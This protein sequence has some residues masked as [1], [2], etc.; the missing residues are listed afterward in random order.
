MLIHLVLYEY[1]VFPFGLGKE[2]S[3]FLI[4]FL[5]VVIVDILAYIYFIYFVPGIIWYWQ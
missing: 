3:R 2:S 5:R 4:L 1:C